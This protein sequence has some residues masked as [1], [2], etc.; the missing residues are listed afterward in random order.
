MPMERS[1]SAY[2]T[3]WGRTQ[4]VCCLWLY[5]PY[6]ILIFSAEYM[7]KIFPLHH[8]IPLTYPFGI[9]VLT[10]LISL[11]PSRLHSI[12]QFCWHWLRKHP[13]LK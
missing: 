11:L 9:L 5:I 6:M 7:Y 12:Y 2:T 8:E 13:C 10:I 4:L 3:R 1:V